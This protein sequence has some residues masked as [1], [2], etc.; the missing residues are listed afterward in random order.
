MLVTQLCLK[1]NAP[2]TKTLANDQLNEIMNIK[3]YEK[4]NVHI[5]KNKQKNINQMI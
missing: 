5:K 3:L 2:T 4:N 1:I